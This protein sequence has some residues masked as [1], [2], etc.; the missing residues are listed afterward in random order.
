MLQ[1]LSDPDADSVSQFGLVSNADNR[2]T[3]IM[4]F[5][6]CTAYAMRPSQEGYESI[7]FRLSLQSFIGIRLRC[8]R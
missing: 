6:I 2:T 7:I 5:S 4:D 1:Q 8:W 3:Q